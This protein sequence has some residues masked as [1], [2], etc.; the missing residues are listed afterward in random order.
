MVLILPCP[1]VA[2][3]AAAVVGATI[4]V[5][6]VAVVDTEIAVALDFVD[7]LAAPAL[8]H[9]YHQHPA[10]PIVLFLATFEVIS[11]F[12]VLIQQHPSVSIDCFVVVATI[13]CS[14][15][16]VS[17]LVVVVVADADDAVVVVV[18]VAAVAKT[19]VVV[20]VVVAA[21]SS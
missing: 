6:F 11:F 9:Q 17:N 13:D 12:L 10:Y 16:T 4:V 20:V 8:R 14:Q 18:V 7:V 3:A 19:S 1:V 5:A 15:W 2:V 21:A